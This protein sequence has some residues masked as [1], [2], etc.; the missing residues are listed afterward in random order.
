MRTEG[1]ELPAGRTKLIHSV[2]V[3]GRVVWVS[4]PTHPYTGIFT[5][6]NHGLLRLSLATEPD[7]AS[8]TTIPGLALKAPKQIY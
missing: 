8:A 3:V 7:P 6:A 2:G 4:L 5:G 1:D